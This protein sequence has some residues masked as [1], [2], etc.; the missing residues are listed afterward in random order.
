[1]A[2]VIY[3]RAVNVFEIIRDSNEAISASRF[4]GTNFGDYF[5]YKTENGARLV[6]KSYY[7]NT[8]VIDETAGGTVET[9]ASAL[10]L[11]IRLK[12]L[13]FF[14][15]SVVPGSGGVTAFKELTDTFP[16]FIGLDGKIL[17][18]DEAQNKIVAIDNPSGNI[19][20]T[21]LADVLSE[22]LTA[23]MAG[24][25]PRVTMVTISGN[26]IPML[27]FQ[28]I[29]TV[30]GSLPDGFIQNGIIEEDGNEIT[31]KT[32]FLWRISNTQYG[33][34][35]DFI[36][37]I[38]PADAGDSR[39]DI[40]VANPDN[41]FELIP[42]T[43]SEGEGNSVQPVVPIGTLLLTSIS[44]YEDNIIDSPELPDL[45]GIYIE[46]EEKQFRGIN[47]VGDISAYSID[48]NRSQLYFI[49]QSTVSIIT[50]I[51]YGLDFRYYK[52]RKF[53]FTHD[54]DLTDDIE[55][56]HLS[57]IGTMQF[58]LPAETSFLLR[59]GETIEF[60]EYF[61]NLKYVGLGRE[62][63]SGLQSVT[64]LNPD[65][66]DNTDP[67]NPVLNVATPD[68]VSSAITTAN[69]YTDSKAAGLVDLRGFY[70]ASTN[71]FPS[72]GGSG[73]SG[74]VLKG[75]L[76]IIS[77]AGTLGG[78]AVNQGD[79]ILA[80]I[81]SPGQTSA[82]WDQSES[83]L[84]FTPENLANKQNSRTADGTGTKYPTVDAMN[85]AL[86][87]YDNIYPRLMY[88]EM[89][90]YVS[91]GQAVDTTGALAPTTIGTASNGSIIY[92]VSPQAVIP[93][94]R[95]TTATTAGSSAHIRE[96]SFN[97]IN[98]GQGFYF[99]QRVKSI[100]PAP[101]SDCRI[102]YGLATTSAIGN[103]EISASVDALLCLGADSTD[104]N[105]QIISKM[106]SGP[107]SKVNLGSSFLKTNSDDYGIEFWKLAGSPTLTYYK[108]TNYTNGA[109]QQGSVTHSAILT[110][111]NHKNNG[112]SALAVAF[113]FVKA[114][115]HVN[116]YY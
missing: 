91:T 40:I 113:D 55:F 68:D 26:T 11:H 108:I 79:S 110:F 87:P 103:I 90:R 37:E 64:A 45:G 25:V 111:Y 66:V 34:I 7:Y 83:N 82:N 86:L 32:G 97:R 52:G 51:D 4:V 18:V 9:F 36:F 1:M 107:A 105:L 23:D 74:A 98:V 29:P 48:D 57:G 94:R 96:P 44:V 8:Q 46:T 72:T 70:N 62:S 27:V 67:S 101:V 71:V 61:G 50:G 41:T 54:Q 42:G 12:Q 47:G 69:A 76:W 19:A 3:K 16:T 77:V 63:F 24:K 115:I 2:D 5:D 14:A 75:D 89:I 6:E 102:L 80:M 38:D 112:A 59:K 78:K 15:Y 85:T 53:S 106:V 116:E 60:V 88:P 56:K 30:E 92:G 17:A 13:G 65:A 81:D 58:V 39:T 104:T 73:N 21:D 20:F 49:P 99:S 100:D 84:G 10:A 35:E 33:N 114:S 95:L 109:I 22:S 43:P 28:D 93:T 31:V